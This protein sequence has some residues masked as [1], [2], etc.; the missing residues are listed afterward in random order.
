MLK[1]QIKTSIIAP[2]LTPD[3]TLIQDSSPRSSLLKYP[4]HEKFSFKEQVPMPLEEKNLKMPLIFLP[5]TSNTNL[6]N[7][8]AVDI[9][10]SIHSEYTFAKKSD[11]SFK[12]K[13]TVSEFQE[14]EHESAEILSSH[15]LVTSN[16]SEKSKISYK[17]SKKEELT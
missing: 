4:Q 16:A 8:I 7:N 2:S 3:E 10:R 17:F 14:K 6:W 1:Y 15:K 5:K 13:H 11:F 9:L 12:K